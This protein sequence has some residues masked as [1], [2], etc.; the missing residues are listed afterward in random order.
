MSLVAYRPQILKKFQCQNTGNCCLTPGYVYVNE[1]NIQSMA[2]ELAVSPEF[3]KDH[4]VQKIN[5]WTVV[6]SPT[7]RTRCFLDANLQCRVYQSRPESCRS[8]PDWDVIWENES[9]LQ[10]E[11]KSCK[12]LAHAI[13]E[14]KSLQ[15]LS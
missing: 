5:G 8:Y 6:A 3:F 4:F 1:Q 12:G 10:K 2:K 14:F 11:A 7:F 13:N 15:T 9:S